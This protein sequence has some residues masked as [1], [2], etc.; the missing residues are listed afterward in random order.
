MRKMDVPMSAKR[1]GPMAA[2]SPGVGKVCPA[3]RIPLAA[4]DYT[5][6]VPIGPGSDAEERR[7]CREGRAYNAVAVEAHCACVTGEEDS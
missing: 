5:T 7:R 6:L 3:C 2:D 1:F 4:G